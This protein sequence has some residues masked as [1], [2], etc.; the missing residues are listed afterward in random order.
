VDKGRP[1]ANLLPSIERIAGG[2]EAQ[3][4]GW[5][6]GLIFRNGLFLGRMRQ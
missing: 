1:V 2:S 5:H 6:D 3:G 4:A